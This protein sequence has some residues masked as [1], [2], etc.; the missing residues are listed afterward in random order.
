MKSL[1]VGLGN[2]CTGCKQRK[3][4]ERKLSVIRGR[5]SQI[6]PWAVLLLTDVSNLIPAKVC[7]TTCEMD[8]LA[9][10]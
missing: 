7:L 6:S 8:R 10:H 2:P 9:G 3:R 4:K 1:A 5:V